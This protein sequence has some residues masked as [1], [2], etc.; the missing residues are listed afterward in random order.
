MRLEQEWILVSCRVL[1]QIPSGYQGVTV[2][3]LSTAQ[4]VGVPTPALFSGQLYFYIYI[5][6]YV[7]II[8]YMYMYVFFKIKKSF[9]LPVSICKEFRSHHSILTS[10]R[11]NR[12]KNQRLG[13]IKHIFCITICL[14]QIML[15]FLLFTSLYL[16]LLCNNVETWKQCKKFL[17]RNSIH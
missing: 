11:C 9:R 7:C 3:R 14:L 8:Y 16:S 10:K 6:V 12:L 13:S 1:K 5:Y 15:F 4:G 17:Y 2:C